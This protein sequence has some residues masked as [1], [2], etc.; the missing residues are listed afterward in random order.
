MSKFQALSNYERPLAGGYSITPFNFTRLDDRD[1]VLTNLAGEFLLLRLSDIVAFVRHDLSPNSDAYN[2]LKAKHFLIDSDSSVAIDLLTLKV[3]TKYSRFAQF[4]GLHML[5]TTLRCDASCQYCQVSRQSSDKHAFDMSIDTAERSVQMVFRSPSPAIKIEFQG[6][7]PLLR[8]DLIQY[9]VERAEELNRVAQRDLQFV[10][11]TNLAL[12]T[13][14]MLEYC[15][16]HNI[17]VSTSL[18]GPADLHNRNRSRPGNDAYE[19]T[20]LGIAKARS[21]L[22]PDRV[23]ALM[24]TTKASLGRATDIVD[25]Y[26]KL[27]FDGVFFRAL[28]PYG[29]A[30]KTKSYSSYDTDHWLRFYF[31]G[32]EYIIDLN[33]GGFFFVEYYAALILTEMLTPYSTGF[34][35]LRSPA[36]IGIGALL[37]NYDGDVYAS[38]ESRML[39][40]MGDKTFRLG[41][42]HSDSWED[43]MTSDALLEPLERSFAASVPLCT[44]CAFEPYCG[45]SPVFHYTTQGD[46]VGHKPTSAFCRRNMAIFR[47]LITKMRDDHIAR[48]IFLSW[49]RL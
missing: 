20:V 8:F 14:T 7:E 45:A 33:R 40:E 43:I 16:M 27:G 36:G 6:G 10:I 26:I 32:L 18:D 31:E 47:Y 13:D 23:S 38:D 9:V 30:V 34:V 3:R 2:A 17:L 49:V 28:S 4:T 42:V 5:V 25:E 48:E 15:K 39:A 12:V 44:D 29:Y 11:A 35:D 21:V 1:Y 24:T 46:P 41:N 19:R 22:G 37:Y